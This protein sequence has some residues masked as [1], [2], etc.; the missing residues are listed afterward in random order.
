MAKKRGGAHSQAMY[1]LTYV[2][3]ATRPFTQQELRSLLVVAR[4][5]NDRSGVT[6][7]L[8]YKD[9]NFMQVLEGARDAV[10]AV[11]ARIETDPRHRGILVLLSGDSPQRQFGSWSM[12]FRDLHGAEGLGLAGYDEFM[13]TPLT[14]PRF[15]DEPS[16]CQ[17]L[18][19]I[20]KRSM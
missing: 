14:D 13:N 15:V 2:S 6:G 16:A 7:M 20:F 12:A 17:K 10:L 19:M 11:K 5:R 8:L 18:L 4:T 1:S 3:S 9:G